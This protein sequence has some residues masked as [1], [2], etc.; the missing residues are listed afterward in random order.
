VGG[1]ATGNT[2]GGEFDTYV[3]GGYEFHTGGF[4]FGP[5]AALQYTYVDVSENTESGSLAPLRIVSKS[6]DSL[7]T[8]LGMSA[9]YAWTTGKVVVTPSVRASWQHEYLYSALPISAQFASGA[10]SVFTVFGPAEGHDSASV[11]V[12]VN[13]QWTPTIGTYF[14]YNGQLGR[15]RYDSQGGVCGVHWEF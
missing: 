10:G 12:G 11:N 8:N 2:S 14:G 13:V 1:T 15:S 9:S 7:R 6:A 5:T 3:S 4:S